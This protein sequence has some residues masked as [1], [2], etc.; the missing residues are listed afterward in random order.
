MTVVDDFGDLGEVEVGVA[1]DEHGLVVSGG[2][3]GGQFGFELAF[4]EGGL[5]DLVGDAVVAVA[6]E[7]DDDGLRLVGA[8]RGSGRLRD[9]SVEALQGDGLN[10]HEDDQ[11]HEKYVDEWGD[12]DLGAEFPAAAG[13]HGHGFRPPCLL[14]TPWVGGMFQ[15]GSSFARM[16]PLTGTLFT[17]FRQIASEINRTN[18]FL[19]DKHAFIGS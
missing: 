9:E 8:V 19:R 12:V 3:D 15:E 16:S 10:D 17:Y 7:L 11:Q 5:V 13:C 14:L 4:V 2:E 6:E 18:S 1:L